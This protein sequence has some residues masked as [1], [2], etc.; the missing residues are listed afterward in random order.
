[1][2]RYLTEFV[3]TFFLVLTIGLAVNYKIPMAPLAIGSM[4][5]VMVYM[6][7]HISGAHYNPAVS[8][9]VVIRGLLTP[10]QMLA[11]WLAQILGAIA[12]ALIVALIIP[13]P[14][15]GTEVGEQVARFFGPAPGAGFTMTSA[16]VW[17]V[18]LL[19][20]G[21][22]CLVVLNVTT[23]SKTQ[24]N[25]YFGLAI[26]FTVAVGAFVGVHISGGAFNPAVSI[27]PNLIQATMGGAPDALQNILLHTA[28]PLVGGAVAA[29]IFRIQEDFVAPPPPKEPPEE[30]VHVH[31]L[32]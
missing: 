9:A 19:F 16:G 8:F 4:L 2:A 12:A 27:G 31:E 20:T 30:E 11:Y 24:G 13:A 23:S 15:E 5:M 6:G 1:M 17:L 18:E 26:G 29:L 32:T 25:S 3:G 14:L 21:A 10:L 7:G 28:G 22:L